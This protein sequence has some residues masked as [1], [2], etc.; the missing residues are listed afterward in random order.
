MPRGDRTGPSGMGP[1]TGRALG[2]CNNFAG[3]GFEKMTPRGMGRHF[4]N[5][6]FGRNYR[7]FANPGWNFAPVN[8]DAKSQ[9][10]YLENEIKTLS[11]QLEELKTRDR[12]SVV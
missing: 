11:D 5:R 9:K 4:G 6:G 1:M 10:V 2:Y 3:P 12:K 8:Y 7:N